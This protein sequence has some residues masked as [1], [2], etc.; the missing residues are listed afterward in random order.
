VEA[1]GGG[2]GP[3]RGGRARQRLVRRRCCTPTLIPS[4]TPA[5]R[6][7]PVVMAGSSCVSVGG[8]LLQWW[9]AHA[10]SIWGRADPSEEEVARE[11]RIP[12]R[13]RCRVWA[14]EV[15]REGRGRARAEKCDAI[16]A[17]AVGGQCDAN[18]MQ[19]TIHTRQTSICLPELHIIVGL[20]LSWLCV[21][22]Q[23]SHPVLKAKP[24]A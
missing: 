6:A 23:L 9:G 11:G 7:P 24:N 15:V 3:G 5:I 18:E 21:V 1:G 16:D 8:E 19:N 22:D 10:T 4:L 17:M 20:G 12:V 13:R 2:G 14:E